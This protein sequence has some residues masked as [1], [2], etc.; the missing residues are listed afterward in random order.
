[1]C[2]CAC[3]CA[4]A[5]VWVCGCVCVL[6]FWKWN[7]DSCHLSKLLSLVVWQSLRIIYKAALNTTDTGI[8]TLSY[9]WKWYSFRLRFPDVGIE[10]SGK[11]TSYMRPPMFP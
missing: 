5:C 4:C 9:F 11:C 3:A 10:C 7:S 6:F 1:M 8:H 2:V